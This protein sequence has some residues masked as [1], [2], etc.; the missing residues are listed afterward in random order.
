[1]KTRLTFRVDISTVPLALSMNKSR[2]ILL[3]TAILFG[4]LV[5]CQNP[6]PTAERYTP[7]GEKPA[8]GH[9][10]PAPAPLVPVSGT[11]RYLS[12]GYEPLEQW[13]DERFKVR[14]ENMPLEMVFEQKPIND[15]RYQKVNLPRNAPVFHLVSANISRREVLKEISSFYN[16]DMNVEM[17]EGQPSYVTVRGRGGSGGPATAA[18]AE[19]GGEESSTGGFRGR[20]A[21]P[22]PATVPTYSADTTGQL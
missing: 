2:P 4:G 7:E 19:S 10:A 20:S 17:V 11:D 1:M 15:I 3:L 6:D 8:F 12:T 13:M 5:G 21:G 9:N 16:L 14:Y 18:P 22:P